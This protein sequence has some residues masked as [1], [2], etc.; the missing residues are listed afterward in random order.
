MKQRKRKGNSNAII[1]GA[2]MLAIEAPPLQNHKK[3]ILEKTQNLWFR[4]KINLILNKPWYNVGNSWNWSKNEPY[5]YTYNNSNTH[6]GSL[7]N[8]ICKNNIH[9]LHQSI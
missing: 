5:G 7:K 9:P 1:A 2:K 8:W 6:S 3:N 4:W